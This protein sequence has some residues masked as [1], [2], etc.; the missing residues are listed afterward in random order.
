MLVAL[1]NLPN[2]GTRVAEHHIWPM[3][4]MWFRASLRRKRHWR[5]NDLLVCVVGL[6]ILVAKK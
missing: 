6:N 3:P 1:Q 2:E 4:G 5:A